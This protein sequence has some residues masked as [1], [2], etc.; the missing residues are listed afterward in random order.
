[1]AM[2]DLTFTHSETGAPVATLGE[3]PA[4]DEVAQCVWWV[5][6]AGKRLYQTSLQSGATKHWTMPEEPGFVVLDR[7]SRPVLG[8]QSGIFAFE[9]ASES[10]TKIAALDRP[11]HRFNDATVDDLGRLWVSTIAMDLEKGAAAIHRVCDDLT[12]QTVVHGLSIPNGMAVDVDRR[13][14]YYSDSHWDIQTIWTMEEQAGAGNFGPPVFFASTLNMPGRPDG[15]ALDADGRYWVAAVDGAALYVYAP[16]CTVET[17]KLLYEVGLPI[18][19]PTKPAFHGPTG[20]LIV[21][22]SK[23]DGAQGGRLAMGRSARGQF[24][25]K[26]Q[27]RWRNR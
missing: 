8:M 3:S 2:I 10:L 12:L 9:T 24:R 7:H 26:P 25:G 21:V 16:H 11:G 19:A 6:T 15:A 17:G 23:A 20:E 14:L 13:Q 22:T 27:A 1:M 4:V 18:Q 5:D